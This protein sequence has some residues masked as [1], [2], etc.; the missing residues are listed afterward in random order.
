MTYKALSM[1]WDL[2]I[3]FLNIQHAHRALLMGLSSVFQEDLLSGG[4]SPVEFSSQTSP[5]ISTFDG[6]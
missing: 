5:P 2:G 1:V 3:P 6:L 4:L